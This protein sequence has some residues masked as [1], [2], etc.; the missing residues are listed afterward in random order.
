M[1]D[2]FGQG[3]YRPGRYFA[4]QP[5]PAD[6]NPDEMNEMWRRA[7][8]AL[9]ETK[10]RE[11]ALDGQE[12]LLAVREQDLHDR[13]EALAKLMK[14]IEASQRELDGRI[15][16]FN[17]DVKMVRT[18][19]VEPLKKAGRTLASLDSEIAAKLVAEWWKTEKGQDRALKILSVMDAD[20][21]DGIVAALPL[22]EMRDF[23]EKRL[24]LTRERIR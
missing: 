22:A 15:V 14:E 17:S 21:A 3:Q 13:E 6:I 24:L 2:L 11:S 12:K 8:A 7:K 4:F 23:L 10:Q 18:N 5:V 9:K 16:Q 1:E 20:S 19:E